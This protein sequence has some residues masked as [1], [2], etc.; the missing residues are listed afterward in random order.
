MTRPSR[1]G[2]AIF[3]VIVLYATPP[4][5]TPFDFAVQ[6]HFTPLIRL[7]QGGYCPFGMHYSCYYEPY[8]WRRCGCWTG[9]VEPACPLGYHF[10]CRYN[11]AGQW[12]CACY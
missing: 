6:S 5:A 12:Q 2:L 7:T 3:T 9:G 1:L 10:T 8:G 4:N 11:P